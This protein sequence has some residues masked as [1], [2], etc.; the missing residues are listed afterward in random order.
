MVRKIEI[1]IRRIEERDK[2]E[3]LS[4][5]RV[6]YASPAVST[7]GSDEIFN[8]DIDNC[9]GGSPYLEGFVFENDGNIE[10]YA[11][12]AKSF[13][14]EFGMPCVWIE[15]IYIKEEAR[16]HGIGKKFFAYIEES[17][18]GAIFRLEVEEDNERALAL[19]KKCG[20][21]FLPYLEMKKEV[22]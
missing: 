12:L 7:N 10:G 2:R 5:M 21:D 8:A 9:I 20:F 17:Y 19:Y 1:K 13:S 15:D 4:M 22:K 6:F 11:M 3:V 14:T 16:G 18:K